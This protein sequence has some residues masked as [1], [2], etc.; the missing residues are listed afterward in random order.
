MNVS[1]AHALTRLEPRRRLRLAIERPARHALLND[2]AGELSLERLALAQRMPGRDLIGACEPT[3]DQVRLHGEL[4]ALV[5][6]DAEIGLRRELLLRCP[7]HVDV[8]SAGIGHGPLQ[9]EHAS[10]PGRVERRLVCLGHDLAEPVHAS[11]VV[12]AIHHATS[13]GLFGKPV[14]IM[15]SRVTSEASRSSLHP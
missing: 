8:P 2:I 4:P 11:H 5:I 9:R 6:G 13:C 10:F 15:Q 7:R 12:N 3:L 14:P 1:R